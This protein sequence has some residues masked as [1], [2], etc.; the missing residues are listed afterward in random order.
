MGD[1]E[2]SNDVTDNNAFWPR[3]LKNKSLE[4]NQVN[5]DWDRY[6]DDED[7]DEK[8]GFDMSA[9]DGG[10]GMGGMDGFDGLGDYGDMGDMD[11]TDEED[12]DEDVKSNDRNETDD[13]PETMT[14]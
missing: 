3:L 2:T 8:G 9:L 10:V 13:H 1:K 14:D 7:E 4:K 6:N 11:S 12:K 5:I